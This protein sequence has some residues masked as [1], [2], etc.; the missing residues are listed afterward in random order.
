MIVHHSSHGP[1]GSVSHSGSSGGVVVR[2]APVPHAPIQKA[3]PKSEAVPL[4][5]PQPETAVSDPGKAVLVLKVPEDATVYLVGHKMSI[6]GTERRYRIPVST[7][8]K[9]FN[10]PVK[11]EV[12]RDGKVLVSETTQKIRGGKRIDLAVSESDVKGEL[13]AVAMR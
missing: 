10:Y 8:G 7:P 9:D 2:H 12:V 3:T 6:T 1:S 5:P 4:A 11:V 13:V